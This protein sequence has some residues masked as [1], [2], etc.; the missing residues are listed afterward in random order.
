[1]LEAVRTDEGKDYNLAPC[2]RATRGGQAPVLGGDSP[3]L[4]APHVFFPTHT[5]GDR[6]LIN[7]PK[8]VRKRRNSN[9][10]ASLTIET[11]GGGT[12][13]G[14]HKV[15]VRSCDGGAG[16][17]GGSVHYPK[18]T[19]PVDS[20]PGSPAAA[21]R[22]S[23]A[24]LRGRLTVTPQRHAQPDVRPAVPLLRPAFDRSRPRSPAFASRSS[25]RSRV[26][27]SSGISS[28]TDA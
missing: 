7:S 24:R 20:T 18:V 1:M 11:F 6:E 2:S 4:L 21:R 9:A 3:N 27:S 17:S 23:P 16:V 22:R 10:C 19:R 8:A 25:A 26:R 5:P 12:R 15:H 14:I 28:G 13:D